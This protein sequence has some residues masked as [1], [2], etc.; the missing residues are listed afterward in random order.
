MTTR[1]G[2]LKSYLRSQ[3]GEQ[4]QRTVDTLVKELERSPCAQHY[5]TRNTIHAAPMNTRRALNYRSVSSRITFT[6]EGRGISAETLEIIILRL[7]CV[8]FLDCL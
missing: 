5:L 4:I 1:S 2:S 7:V 3:F 8:I 6:D